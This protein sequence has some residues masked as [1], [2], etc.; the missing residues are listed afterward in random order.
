MK[1]ILVAYDGEEPAGRA[2]ELGAQLA[3]A[4]GAAIGVVC[5][6]PWRR[7]SFPVDL[8]DDP[9]AR[10]KALNAAGDWLAARGLSA[11]LLSPAGELAQTIQSVAEDGEFDTIVVGSRGLGPVARFMQGSVSEQLATDAK[12]TVVIARQSSPLSIAGTS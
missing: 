5:V 3:K 10:E 7:D 1:R 9:G 6:S 4:F 11:E 8:W 12:A 2:L